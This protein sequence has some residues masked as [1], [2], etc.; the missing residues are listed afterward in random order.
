MLFIQV[1]II[2]EE[3]LTKITLVT[4]SFLKNMARTKPF[5]LPSPCTPYLKINLLSKYGILQF[6][7]QQLD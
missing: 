6:L 2:M 4:F 1:Y 3:Q 7:I 5:S